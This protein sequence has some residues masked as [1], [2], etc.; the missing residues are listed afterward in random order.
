M[1]LAEQ[2]DAGVRVL[3]G[4]GFADDDARRDAGVLARFA[5]GWDGATWLTRLGEAAPDD[6]VAAFP[7]LIARR[8]AREPVAYITGQ[9]EFYGR[10]FL[11][12][13]DVLIPRPETELLVDTAL[14]HLR[15]RRP[16][17][18]LV[19]V[20]TGSGCLAITLALECPAARVIA[21]DVSAAALGVARRNAARLGVA[22]RIDFRLG[23][24]LGDLDEPV[25]LVVSNPPY[26]AAG[27]RASLAAD[28]REFE[29]HVALFGGADGLAIVRDLVPLAARALAPGA[30]L[31]LE[32]G[33]GQADAVGAIVRDAGLQ[34]I[35]VRPDLQGIPRVLVAARLYNPAMS[36]CLFCRII[37]GEVPAS[38][39]YEDERMVAFNDIAPHAPMHV[40][41]VPRA[42][43]ATLNDLRVEHDDLAGALVR[44]GAAIA[45][46]RGYAAS[47][48]RTVFNCNADAG[49]AVFH[50]HLHVLGGRKMAWPPG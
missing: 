11:V 22:G 2:V 45:A 26:V 30:W 44:R 49:Q 29:P 9:R 48:Y 5:L 47:G 28:V 19:D 17:P 7:P 34:A 14:E 10:S 37:A 31:I 38:L 13:P 40:L 3:R 1:T 21:T 35:G 8:A 42:H 43:I 25:D 15:T 27:D 20:G 32:I 39:V 6:F 33:A 41:V 4:A 16:A 23:A 24:L 36:N 18:S 12:T 46:A 50:I